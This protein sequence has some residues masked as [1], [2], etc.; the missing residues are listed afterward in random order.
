[1]D[2][3]RREFVK[4]S[5][6]LAALSVAGTKQFTTSE[7]QVAEYVQ[8]GGIQFC[9]AH[10]FGMNNQRIEL[11]KQMRVLGAVGGINPKSVGLNNTNNWEYD[12]I[13]AVRDAWSTLR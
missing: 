5:V 10:F 12:A 1:M 8:D 4:N 2:N 9:L 13:V 7:K 11:S 3:T 6:S